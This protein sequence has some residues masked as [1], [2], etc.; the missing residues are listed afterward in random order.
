[1]TTP[2]TNEQTAR[3][4][5]PTNT[6]ACHFKKSD[7]VDCL[8]HAINAPRHGR[9]NVYTDNPQ[10]ERRPGIYLVHDRG[11]Y[12]MSTGIYDDV[13]DKK[14][15]Y[16]ENCNPQTDADW[17]YKSRDLVGGD[18][19]VEFFPSEPLLSLLQETT[20]PY[21]A[22]I[23]RESEIEFDCDPDLRTIAASEE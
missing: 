18:D 20:N 4:Q 22:V 16:A 5:V 7:V 13:D 10:D 12:V 3:P 14:I 2:A 6:T 17:W 9:E 15:T 8:M 11:V 21:V 1:M 19:F 23:V